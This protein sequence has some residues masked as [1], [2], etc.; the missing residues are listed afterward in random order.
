MLNKIRKA[1]AGLLSTLYLASC[2]PLLNV[3]AVS[4]EKY[5]KTG[6]TVTVDSS[7]GLYTI[8]GLPII[9][10]T[11]SVNDSYVPKNLVQVEEKYFS[12]TDESPPKINKDAYDAFKKLS[13]GLYSDLFITLVQTVRVMLRQIKH[14]HV[15]VIQTIIPVVQLMY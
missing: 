3:G 9:N 1:F 7:V 6:K 4:N 15:L 13:D 12:W 10:K 5:T 2:L 11:F 14:H 8:D